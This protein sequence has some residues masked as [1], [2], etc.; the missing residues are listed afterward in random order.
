MSV[1]KVDFEQKPKKST[2][3]D[4]MIGA[5]IRQIRRRVKMTMEQLA[6]R[7][8]VSMQALQKYETGVCRISG[9]MMVKLADELGVPITDLFPPEAM[10]NS[11]S[12][13]DSS[14]AARLQ[15]ELVE[16]ASSLSVTKLRTA[17]SMVRTLAFG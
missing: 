13:T 6:P 14:E 16:V 1:R 11:N 12:T 8:G 5:N 7:L 9:G 3:V 4:L 10:R 2:S 17:L 15:L